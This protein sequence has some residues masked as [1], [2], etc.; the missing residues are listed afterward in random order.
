M[1]LWRMTVIR[2]PGLEE[3]EGIALS[4]DETLGGNDRHHA[5]LPVWT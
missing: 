1:Q 5:P 4:R 2:K 3:S